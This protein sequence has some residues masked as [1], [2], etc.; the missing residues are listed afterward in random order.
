MK[1]IG[2]VLSGAGVYDGAELHEAVLTL[3]AIDRAGATAVCMAP[4][5][6][7]HHVMNHLSG[8]EEPGETRNVLV[9]SARIARG[10]IQ[11]L[12]TVDAGSLDAL[13]F[14][15]GIGA[16]KNLCDF[17]I[18]GG[19][20]KVDPDVEKL[21]QAVARAGKPIGAACIA[22]A[23]IARVFKGEKQVELTIGNDPGTAE[24]LTKFG[25]RHTDCAVEDIVI[26]RQNKLV[27]T[28]AY[29]LAQR[30]SEA[31]TGIEKMIQ[32]VIEMA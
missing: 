17:A 21:I 12:A 5:I 23:L 15:G 22:P 29:M 13:V 4:N 3:L 11:D 9:E 20:C 2:V 1:K 14:P 18:H 32:A 19:D 26:D 16:V 30:I 31:S 27:T 7:Q 10:D 28:P 25:A 24:A 8:Q 6:A